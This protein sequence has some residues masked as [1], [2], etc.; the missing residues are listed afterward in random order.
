M[1]DSDQMS[2]IQ[3]VHS[4]KSKIDPKI[5]VE[6]EKASKFFISDQEK[7]FYHLYLIFFFF[8]KEKYKN[9]FLNCKKANEEEVLTVVE[10]GLDVNIRNENGVTPLHMAIYHDHPGCVAALCQSENIDLNATIEG[11]RTPL[12][13]A[14]FHGRTQCLEILLKAKKPKSKVKLDQADEIEGYTPL[15]WATLALSI[16]GMQLLLQA[17]AQIRFKN[18]KDAHSITDAFFTEGLAN[19]NDNIPHEIPLMAI[20]ANLIL[21]YFGKIKKNPK[22]K[23]TTIVKK[24]KMK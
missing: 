9:L 18:G 1:K 17:G 7:N 6:V 5:V 14:A 11:G 24:I 19:E 20:H 16:K 15:M 12:C 8:L 22:K 13:L 3:L 23:K 21:D 10:A 4:L 2:V